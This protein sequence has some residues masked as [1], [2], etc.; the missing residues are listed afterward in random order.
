MTKTNPTSPQMRV[1]VHV[2]GVGG[3]VCM[4]VCV[5]SRGLYNWTAAQ[6]A[7]CY[8]CTQSWAG[9]N[10]REEQ[11]Q[12]REGKEG[13]LGS[14]TAWP[15]VRHGGGGALLANCP[16]CSALRRRRTFVIRTWPRGTFSISQPVPV[17]CKIGLQCAEHR[18]CSFGRAKNHS[19]SSFAKG[20]ADSQ[21]GM[22]RVCVWGPQSRVPSRPG[23]RGEGSGGLRDAV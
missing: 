15:K 22:T 11:D 17:W 4:C 5:F 7:S 3:W 2:C 23:W 13:L 12:D 14:R 16:H 9:S 8:L 21:Q 18:A 19:L 10:S 1:C 6:P 20:S